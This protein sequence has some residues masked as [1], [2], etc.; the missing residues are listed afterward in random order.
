MEDEQFL[1][2]VVEKGQTAKFS[3]HSKAE[4]L[5]GFV[6]QHEFL[7]PRYI[8]CMAHLPDH[9][10]ENNDV[11]ALN[12]EDSISKKVDDCRRHCQGKPFFHL[13]VNCTC[14]KRWPKGGS[15]L[16]KLIS[17]LAY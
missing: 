16:Y 17:Y 13:S 11:M 15:L 10:E 1:S 2:M 4:K 12:V 3:K 14:L 6:C 8:G 9:Q 7:E 5:R